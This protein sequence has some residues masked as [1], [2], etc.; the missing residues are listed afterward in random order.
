MPRLSINSRIA[1]CAL[2]CLAGT[3]IAQPTITSLGSG[4]PQGVSNPVSG[5]TYI[6]GSN[7]QA[8]LWTLNGATLTQTAMGGAG[9]GRISADGAN[10]VGTALHSPQ[11]I[12]GN[13]ATGVTPAFSTTPTL[14]STLLPANENFAR[15]WD[16][17]AWQ[18]LGGLP[19]T[20]SLMV[21]GSGSSG[22]S[23]GNFMSPHNISPN[24]RY[25][26]GQG[27]ISSYNSAAGTTISNNTFQWRAWVHDSLTATTTVLP[28]P[29]RTSSNTWRRRTG[30][31]YAVS[32]DGL[33]ILG[34]QEHNVAG[35]PT[36]DPDG[37]RPV[38]WRWNSGTS[39]YD[40][41]Y[42]PNGV[43]GSGFPYTVSST[44]GTF[45]MNS[46]GTIIVGTAV[47]NTGNT[48]LAKWTWNA[49]TSS[50]NAPTIL[51][52]GTTLDTAATWLPVSVTSCGL[53]P[54]LSITGMSED[55]NTVV[56]TAVYSTCG[57]FMSGGFIWTNATN[58]IM[59][60]Y[61]FNVAAG[62]PNITANYG[63]VEDG[64]GNPLTGLCKLGFP[65]AI[66]PDG[67][68]IAGFQG[69]TQV[70]PGAPPWVVQLTGGT[71]CV[72]PAV[73]LNPTSPTNFSACTSNIILNAGALGTGPLTYQ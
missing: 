44:P 39:Q 7:G 1:I 54:R 26:C 11:T 40:M 10:F 31:A 61:D 58:Q 62:T 14:V 28:T 15:R 69:G 53:P 45:Q 65:S 12:S 55:G 18:S 49:G 17:S 52:N 27:Y 4:T 34:A 67:N 56:G 46:T 48:F 64:D 70:I 42:L 60:W 22:G 35:T 33:V 50:W 36:A 6:S 23:G 13:T 9:G 71:A 24:G 43:N 68:T 38:V 20:P 29:F 47:D 8:V 3:A 66:S 30:N 72:A 25:V 32:N 19:I 73:T 37:G 63:P 59:D 51:G 16:G 57:S 5:T 21:Y 41:S 2:A